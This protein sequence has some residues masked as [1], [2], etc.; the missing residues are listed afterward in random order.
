LRNEPG[1]YR[2]SGARIFYDGPQVLRALD[3]EALA[4][5]SAL[6]SSGL[7]ARF[8]Q[9]GRLVGTELVPG[10]AHDLVGGD[11]KYV[12]VLR[13][14]RIPFVSYPYE[15]APA[16]LRQAALLQLELLD[17]GLEEGL[18][19][20]D[21]SPYNVQ[22]RGSLPVFI[23]V[24]SFE[25]LREGEPWAGYRQF[26][27]LFLYPLL[28]QVHKGVRFQPWLRGALEGIEP[29]EM[30]RLLSLRDRLR[31]GVL[32]H[33][34]LHSRLSR[35]YGDSSGSVKRELREA[36]FRKELIQANARRLRKLVGR[37]SWR[38]GRSE[39][40]EYRECGHYS[41]DEVA[42]K[43]DFVEQ[44]AGT[45]RWRLV[46][47]LGCNDGRHARIAS[48]HADYVVA[49][50]ADSV[51]VERLFLELESEGNRKILPLVIDLA[52]PSPAVGWRGNERS[53]LADRGTPDLVLCLAL[54]HHLSLRRNVPLAECVA[55]LRSLGG[56]LVVEFPTREDPMAERLLSA[57]AAHVHAD[58]NTDEFER[59]LGEAF[60][61]ER[62][63]PLPGGTRIL[64]F[65]Q[66]RGA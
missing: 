65:A 63:E 58:Y 23:D 26:C 61:I 14:E 3:E 36:G 59:R 8:H 1:S 66:P 37:L 56:A 30:R 33:V 60:T 24:G 20:K 2:D 9:E 45:R 54:V 22:W 64:Y 38:P 28:L 12:A 47:D 49:M 31:R 39:W 48:A 44:A 57:T 42:L 41:D 43:D 46:W 25:R 15:W 16:M 11:S 40:S 27:M 13:H 29:E 17:Q 35:R 55:W 34:V 6:S 21:G 62:R 18:L 4:D 53:P 19:L 50:D 10:A 32:T 7:W 51:P 5:W 52:D